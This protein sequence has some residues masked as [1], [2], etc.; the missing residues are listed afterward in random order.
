MAFLAGYVWQWGH[1]PLVRPFSLSASSGITALIPGSSWRGEGAE[2]INGEIPIRA[3]WPVLSLGLIIN[4]D[5]GAAPGD[6]GWE[7]CPSERWERQFLAGIASDSFQETPGQQKN[8]LKKSQAKQNLLGAEA[9]PGKLLEQ[10]LWEI[11]VEKMKVIL[12]W[13]VWCLNIPKKFKIKG[14]R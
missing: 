5:P 1:V 14:K 13:L 3:T 7:R 9:P 12:C 10:L 8:E 11:C 2:P 6:S 4:L